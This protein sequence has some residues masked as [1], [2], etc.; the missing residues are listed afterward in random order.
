MNCVRDWSK[1]LGIGVFTLFLS[2]VTHAQTQGS[3][4]E[5]QKSEAIQALKDGIVGE[6]Y[7]IERLVESLTAE[8][9]VSLMI[10]PKGVGKAT[11]AR[12]ASALLGLQGVEY[13]L[14]KSEIPFQQILA[15]MGMTVAEGN[16]HVIIIDHIELLSAEE[17]NQIAT[18]LQQRTLSLNFKTQKGAPKKIAVDLSRTRFVLITDEGANLFQ[19]P[20]GFRTSW[21]LEPDSDQYLKNL[22]DERMRRALAGWTVTDQLVKSA[23]TVIPVRRLNAAEFKVAI[24]KTLNELTSHYGETLKKSITIDRQSEL[25]ETIFNQIFKNS[26]SNYHE[27]NEAV[28]K[29]LPDEAI[30]QFSSPALRRKKSIILTWSD[31]SLVFTPLPFDCTFLASSPKKGK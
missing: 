8:N 23:Q 21:S 5:K 19:N 9:A 7:S 3:L 22:S 10:G 11:L 27:L 12:N 2:S 17:Q 24:D 29:L 28:Y 20:V 31:Q 1:W 30:A 18:L 14:A 25:V 13:D 6:D 15:E 26:V 4:S 16:A